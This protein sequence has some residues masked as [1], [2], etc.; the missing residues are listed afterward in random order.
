MSK[1]VPKGYKW[2][3]KEERAARIAKAQ[4]MRAEGRTFQEVADAL[5]VTRQRAFQL[6]KSVDK[7]AAKA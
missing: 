7:K 2:P 3:S 6:L 1:G 5:G 4:A